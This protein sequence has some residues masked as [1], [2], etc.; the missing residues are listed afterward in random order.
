MGVIAD[1][2]GGL[3]SNPG[4]RRIVPAHDATGVAPV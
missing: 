4:T 2:N 3:D 1:D